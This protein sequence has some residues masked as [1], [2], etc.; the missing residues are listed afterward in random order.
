MTRREPA[1][2]TV[3]FITHPDVVID[4]AIPVPQWRLS[5]RGIERMRAMLEQPWVRRISALYC[6]TEQKALDAAMVLAPRLSLN[7]QA[8]EELGEND[9]SSTGY[10][11][12]AEFQATADLFFAHP[13]ASIRGWET[14][15][16]AQQRIVRAIE[17]IVEQ[18]ASDA[19]IAVIAHG[20]VGT[21]YLCHLKR[22]AISRQEEQPGSGGGN[23]YAFAARTKALLHGWK[24]IDAE[25]RAVR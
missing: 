20:G 6:S 14:A 9:R 1:D 7:H 22:Q 16:A 21:L 13:E 11:P 25:P 17:S 2:R 24:P 23:F 12:A 8:C 4:A 18:D 5:P 19:D 15:A 10:L 3:Y